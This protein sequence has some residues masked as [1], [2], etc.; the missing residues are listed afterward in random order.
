MFLT[1]IQQIFSEATSL[2]VHVT[3]YTNTLPCPVVSMSDLKTN[4]ASIYQDNPN[5]KPNSHQEATGSTM[6]KP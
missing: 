6:V 4:K 1:S 2:E 3:V 5:S